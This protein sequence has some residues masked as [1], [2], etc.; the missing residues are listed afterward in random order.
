MFSQLPLLLV[1]YSVA[2]SLVGFEPGSRNLCAGC[3]TCSSST[4]VMQPRLK[5]DLPLTSELLSRLTSIFTPKQ[6]QVT[7]TSA[8]APDSTVARPQTASRKPASYE[9]RPLSYVE[10]STD[11]VTGGFR[12]DLGVNIRRFSSPINISISLPSIMCLQPEQRAASA[13]RK[14]LSDAGQKKLR[15]L[16]QLPMLTADHSI[17]CSNKVEKLL[18]KANLD[19]NSKRYSGEVLWFAKWEGQPAKLKFRWSESNPSTVLFD[20]QMAIRWVEEWGAVGLLPWF[21]S[22]RTYSSNPSE[23]AI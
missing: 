23:I 7:L 10:C 22:T 16:A 6:Q 5:S 1:T 17:L 2:S 13:S 18:L 11:D 21:S 9:L 3:P 19:L 12:S 14:R 8:E 20:A 4:G 15:W